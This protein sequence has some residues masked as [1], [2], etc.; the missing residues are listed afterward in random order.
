MFVDH[1]RTNHQGARCKC[2]FRSQ[3]LLISTGRLPENSGEEQGAGCVFHR[4]AN[5]G[6][7]P[8]GG[9]VFHRK[10]DSGEE[11]GAGS[12]LP[13]RANSGEEPGAGLV[14]HGKANSGEQPGDGRVELG[15]KSGV[16]CVLARKATSG[17]RAKSSLCIGS[18]LETAS[19]EQAA[20]MHRHCGHVTCRASKLSSENYG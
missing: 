6:E 1:H 3:I 9:C 8:G 7:E 10:A 15:R 19:Q 20:I 13:R 12:V 11:P 16:R 2:S 14:L 5:Q 4:K 18:E 17:Q